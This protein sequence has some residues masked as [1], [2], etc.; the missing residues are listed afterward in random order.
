VLTKAITVSPQ[1]F[2]HQRRSILGVV[3]IAMTHLHRIFDGRPRRRWFR[4][5]P[6]DEVSAQREVAAGLAVGG[7]L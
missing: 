3:S 1:S 4:I 6:F 5:Q 2:A 7:S